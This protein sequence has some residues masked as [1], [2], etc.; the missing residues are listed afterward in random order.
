VETVAAG[1]AFQAAARVSRSDQEPCSDSGGWIDRVGPFA[2]ATPDRRAD[3]TP[4]HH[5]GGRSAVPRTS[6]QRA[7]SSASRGPHPPAGVQAGGGTPTSSYSP[8]RPPGV[9]KA[10]TSA[11]SVAADPE[12]VRQPERQVEE[13]TVGQLVRSP[14]PPVLDPALEHEQRLRPPWCAGAAASRSR[15]AGSPATSRS[16]R[17]CPGADQV[18]EERPHRPG[19]GPSPPGARRPARLMALL[20]D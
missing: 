18:L 9:V 3:P 1:P 7:I 6:F 2:R 17:R 4:P 5:L 14:R 13:R 20:P 19:P 11:G 10:R 8:I 15:A 12:R 16:G